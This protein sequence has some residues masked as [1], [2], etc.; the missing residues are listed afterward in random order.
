M[1]LTPSASLGIYLQPIVHRRWLGF[2]SI[3]RP[4]E[5]VHTSHDL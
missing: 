1:N 2:D 3:L 4:A 5:M